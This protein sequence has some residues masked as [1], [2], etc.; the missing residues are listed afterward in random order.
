MASHSNDKDGISRRDFAARLGAA[1]AGV[2]VGGELVT[3]RADAAP[4]VG[5]TILG[6]NDRVVTYANSILPDRG[7]R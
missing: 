2:A 6:A 1:A 5:N 4:H 3:A 7:T